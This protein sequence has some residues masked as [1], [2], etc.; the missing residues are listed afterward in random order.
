MSSEAPKRHLKFVPRDS[1]S[2]E[3][4]EKYSS[5][6]KCLNSGEPLMYALIGRR[7]TGKTQM[8]SSVIQRACEGGISSLYCKAMDFFI[9]LKATYGNQDATEQAVFSKHKI[10]N[11]LVIDEIQVRSESEW[12]NN[13]LTHLIDKRYDAMKSTIFIGNLKPNSLKDCVGESVYSRL[14]EIG[15][16]MDCNWESLRK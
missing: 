10:P 14:T 5:L 8:A 11:L 13:A 7:G 2:E 4:T 1:Q 12:E 9:N 3:W 15:G 16:V 6:V